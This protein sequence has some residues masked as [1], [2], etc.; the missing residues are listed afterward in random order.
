MVS[1]LTLVF[2][3]A[4]RIPIFE[5]MGS[6]TSQVRYRLLPSS[7]R[8]PARDKTRIQSDGD[9]LVVL[10]D[11]HALWSSVAVDWK[12]LRECAHDH[13]LDTADA[14]AWDE[15]RAILSHS[16]GIASIW[17][18]LSIGWSDEVAYGCIPH[19]LDWIVRTIPDDWSTASFTAELERISPCSTT[20]AIPI[21]NAFHTW[22]DARLLQLTHLT[23]RSWYQRLQ[24]C[25]SLSLWSTTRFWTSLLTL[26]DPSSLLHQWITFEL[27]GWSW[28]EARDW[29]PSWYRTSSAGLGVMSTMTTLVSTT[30]C[31]SRSVM[32][33]LHLARWRLLPEGDDA[34]LSW[35][36]TVFTQSMTNKTSI[37]SLSEYRSIDIG[38]STS[39]DRWT[40]ASGL[41]SS[42]FPLKS[43]PSSVHDAYNRLRRQHPTL[44]WSTWNR[45]STAPTAS[46]SLPS[47]ATLTSTTITNLPLVL[48]TSSDDDSDED[49]TSS[50]VIRSSSILDSKSKP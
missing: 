11:D 23:T 37:C 13:K 40:V 42:S 28:T 38:L 26:S 36:R 32:N 49:V 39:P 33:Y 4:N 15:R 6:S 2:F 50:L 48:A 44:V 5:H 7:T 16:D 19:F 35:A 18:R 1:S 10:W 31:L 29:I 43:V 41:F 24:W 8:P 46:P 47:S 20:L 21:R 3:L 14:L 17:K 22:V 30:R 9:G 12:S 34:L 45:A 25:R 27:P